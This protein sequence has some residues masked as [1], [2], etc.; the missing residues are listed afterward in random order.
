MVDFEPGEYMRNV[1][2]QSVTQAA[3]EEKNPSTPS[4]R[5]NL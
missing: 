5:S 3:L 1:I 4:R 2:F